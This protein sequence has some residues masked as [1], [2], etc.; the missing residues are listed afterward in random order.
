[1]CGNNLS[2]VIL[3][4]GTPGVGKTTIGEILQQKG[5]NV[6][7][8]N[9][10]IIE[11]GYYYGFDFSRDTVIIDEEKLA[12]FLTTF[13]ENKTNILFIEGHFINP[14]PTNFVEKIFIIRCNPNILRKRLQS[15][16]KYSR[17]KI[18]ENISAEIF[19]EC[20]HSVQEK[21]QSIPVLELDASDSSPEN[22]VNEILTYITN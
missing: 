17:K 11:N 13:I 3:I 15:S 12:E 14:V 21:F 4:T 16:R 2:R 22:L 7:N 5:F 19:E 8:L 10:L 9:H 1:M 20:L 6:L 18:E